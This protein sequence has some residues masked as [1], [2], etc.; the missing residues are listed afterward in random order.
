MSQDPDPRFKESKFLR[1]LDELKTGEKQIVGKQL[2][3]TE[4]PMEQKMDEAWK[5]AK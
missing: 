4:K 3:V 2:I 1:F 5:V